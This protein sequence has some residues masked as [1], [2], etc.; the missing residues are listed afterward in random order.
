MTSSALLSPAA[1]IRTAADTLLVTWQ[2]PATRRY[3]AVG[4]L[5]QLSDRSYRFDYL[6]AAQNLPRFLPFLGFDTL[7][8][9]YTS[10]HL[11]PLFAQ[12]VLDECRPD[13][14]SLYEALE[15]AP[16]AQPM[17]FLARSGGRRAGDTIELLP[18]PD[19]HA[20]PTSCVFLVHGVRHLDGADGAIERLSP[21]QELSL[22]P[23]PDNPVDTAAVLV[24]R[25]GTR[26]GWVPNPLLHYVSA[27]MDAGRARLRVVR[28]NSRELGHH[29]RLLV[30]L[31]GILD[32]AL[33]EPWEMPYR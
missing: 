10:P 33:R 20:G 14:R 3:H 24:T 21:G 7:D 9:T 31:D 30:R 23:D 8:R 18:A 19:I 1:P 15:L 32:D 11:F 17:E 13:R 29:L 16:A 12:R 4:L 6:A 22:S 5:E 2:D 28:V 27:V 25:D 26:L